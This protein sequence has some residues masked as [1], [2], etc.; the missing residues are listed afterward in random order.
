MHLTEDMCKSVGSSTQ[1]S[2]WGLY[3]DF[4]CL[5]VCL[6]H[7]VVQLWQLGSTPVSPRPFGQM[8]SAPPQIHIRHPLAYHHLKRAPLHQVWCT[9]TIRVGD[10]STLADDGACIAHGNR[11]SSP[12]SDAVCLTGS[13]GVQGETWTTSDKS[14]WDHPSWSQQTPTEVAV[15]SRHQNPDRAGNR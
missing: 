5:F 9:T 11:H 1:R 6:C 3:R 13:H 14:P 4:V 12:T 2:G 8:P 10:R 7:F 15:W